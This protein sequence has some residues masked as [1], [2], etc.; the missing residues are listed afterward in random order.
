MYSA[1]KKIIRKKKIKGKKRE[2]QI[3][4]MAI[5]MFISFSILNVFLILNFINLLNSRV[6][7]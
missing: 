5:I 2:K 7:I 6:I 3:L 1:I 4:N